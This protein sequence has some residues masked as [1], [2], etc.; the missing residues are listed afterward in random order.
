[1]HSL[2]EELA[3]AGRFG[4]EIPAPQNESTTC[5]WVVL[6]LLWALGYHRYEIASRSYDAANKLPDYTILPGSPHTWYLEA[7]AWSAPLSSLHVDQAL[8]YAHT[9][10]KRWVVLTNGREWQ[11][12]DDSIPG[13]SADRLVATARLSE[14]QEL[15][16]FLLAVSKESLSNGDICKYANTERLRSFLASELGRPDS[17]LV[18]AMLTVVR[19]KVPSVNPDDIVSFVAK[20]RAAQHKLIEPQPD[21]SAAQSEAVRESSAPLS[22]YGNSNGVMHIMTPVKNEDGRTAE[23]TIRTLLDSGWYVFGD[24][25]AGRKR[26][27]AGDRICF[28]E[29]GKGVV[30][31]A[32]VRSSAELGDVPGVKWPLKYR[33][34]FRVSDPRYYFEDPIAITPGLRRKLEAFKDK[35]PDSK[36]WSWFVQGTG[37][38][39][40]NDFRMLTGGR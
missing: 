11:L 31:D 30:A 20:Q 21:V 3:Q 28:Y 9:N 19:A 4:S 32:V 5:E 18:K 25:T 27:K 36:L 14:P 34:R 1:M 35:D 26:L 22:T 6:P 33:W 37:I 17:Q 40:E 39:T 29:A 7:K 24:G 13:V 10:G 38:V 16:H 15:R 2:D 12:F 23:E 8:N